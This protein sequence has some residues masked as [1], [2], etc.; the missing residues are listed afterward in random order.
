MTLV[1]IKIFEKL[2]NGY[3]KKRGYFCHINITLAFY[4]FE[5]DNVL[6]IIIVEGFV[7]F[8]SLRNLF[9]TVK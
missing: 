8:S 1:R 9:V 7:L 3:E 4:W 2:Y 5:E 6:C